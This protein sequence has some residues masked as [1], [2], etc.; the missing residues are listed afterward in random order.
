MLRNFF[1]VKR[2][3][4]LPTPPNISYFWNFRSTIRLFLVIQITTRIFLTMHYSPHIDLAFYSIIHINNDVPFGSYIRYSHCNGASFFMLLIYLHIFRGI[5][6]KR[7]S[8]LHAWIA[9]VLLLVLS[10]RT[11]F[12][13]YVLPW[14]QISYWRATVITNLVSAIPVIRQK[15]VF[16]VWGRFSVDLPTLN[17]FYTIHFLLPFLIAFLSLTHLLLIHNKRSRNPLGF[18]SPKK[19]DF[20]PWFGVKDFLRFFFFLRI[21]F[22]IVL[23][24]PEHFGDPDNF[25]QANSLV[26][27]PHIKPEWYFLFAYAILRSIPNKLLRVLVLVFSILV[28]RLLPFFKK[29]VTFSFIYQLVF[30]LWISNVI[31]LTWLRG[32]PV[33]DVFTYLSQLSGIM[34]FFLLF[35]LASIF[36][37]I[38]YNIIFWKKIETFS[39]YGLSYIC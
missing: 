23:F 35:L 22:F 18:F 5:Y 4:R 28:F 7:Y 30:W 14:R 1:L 38:I 25:I 21:F 6:Y 20:W 9:R 11:A 39:Y 29:K 27:P 19:I 24:Y 13:G 3:V 15:I 32:C 17:R 8:N 2:L 10:I 16:W 31:L 26:T 37:Y 34:Y 36:L 12:F 33:K